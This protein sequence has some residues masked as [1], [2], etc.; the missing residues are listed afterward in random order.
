[1]AQL[2]QK[3]M[4][5][6]SH[7]VARW[8]QDGGD[9]KRYQYKL[10]ANSIIVDLGGYEGKFADTMFKKF[11]CKVYVFE[12]ISSFFNQCCQTNKFNCPHVTVYPLGI[13]GYTDSVVE[14]SVEGD[15]SS[16]FK[17]TGNV[18]KESIRLAPIADLFNGA[19]LTLIKIDV[20]KINVEG[21]EFDILDA[22]IKQRFIDKIQN[23]QVQFHNFVPDAENRRTALHAELSKTHHLTYNYP[24]VWENWELNNV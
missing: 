6:N 10:D 3:F 4:Y 22:L 23:V 2:S 7:D 18:R 19:C 1:M 13:S 9:T 15:A 24:F 11:G 8:F 12:P 16:I 14:I 17:A 21:A 20:L 5:N